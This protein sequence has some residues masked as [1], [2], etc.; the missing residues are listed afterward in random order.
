MFHIYKLIYSLSIYRIKH[1]RDTVMSKGLCTELIAEDM[2]TMIITKEE[3]KN[4]I[5]EIDGKFISPLAKH[6]PN[7]LPKESHICYWKGFFPKKKNIR[8]VVIHLAGTGDHSYVRRQWGFADDL[9]KK[10]IASILIENPYYGSRKPS[11]QFR[12]SLLNVTDLF[13]LGGALM[14][15]CNYLLSYAK[16]NFGLDVH[17]ISGVSMG[18]FTASL[19]ASNIKYPISLVPCLSWTC[20][21]KSYTY[22]AISEAIKWDTLKEEL[23]STKFRNQIESIPN[24][25]WLGELEDTMK[26]NPELDEAKEFMRILMRE[27]TFLGNYPVIAEPKLCKVIV[28]Q[29]DSYV[30][31]HDLPSFDDIWPGSEVITLPGYGHVQS[32]FAYHHLFRKYIEETMCSLEKSL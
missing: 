11:K 5:V 17:G 21:S 31:R 24:Q 4:N 19:A 26:N 25:N 20:A 30:L 32:Y 13:V 29:S 1:F 6:M 9:L 8:K 27:F 28:A 12:S 2:P 18:G 23:S 14:T 3:V 10:D 7:I 22:G 15:E 16:T